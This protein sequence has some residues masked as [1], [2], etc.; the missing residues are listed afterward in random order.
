MDHF[1]GSLSFAKALDRT[2]VLPPWVEYHWP[3]PRSVQVPFKTYFKVEPLLEYH[4][5]MTM[6]KFM[7]EL[8][9]TLWPPGNRTVF[10]YQE[11]G[12]GKGC[13]AKDGNPFGPFWDTFD[14]DFDHSEFFYPLYHDTTSNRDIKEWMERYPGDKWPVIAFTGAPA[15]FPVQPRSAVLQKYLHWSNAVESQANKFITDNFGDQPFIG[16]H[17]RLGSDFQS[18]CG[19]LEA[20]PMMFAAA[21]CLG[22]RGEKGKA[23]MEMCYPP[24][25]VIVKQVKAAVKKHKA[26]GVFIATDSRD[27]IDKFSKSM[28]KV[29]FVKL[30]KSN[31]HVDLAIL[32][33]A[34]HYIGNC[35]STFSAIATRERNT[36][37]K[38]TEFW[39]FKEKNQHE[40]L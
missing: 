10:C 1:L 26:V 5:V 19:H 17:L 6:E 13:N 28:K 25:D 2:L 33:Q 7:S 22:Y 31:P 36:K 14:V 27:L 39:A 34:T 35:I 24:D 37:G 15:P 20:S 40:E 30:S 18:A 16:I 32:G 23:T 8:A 21:Q 38:T 9:P 3:K 12:E 4:R 11:R 29:K